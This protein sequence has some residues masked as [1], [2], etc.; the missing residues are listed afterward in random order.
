M[1]KESGTAAIRLIKTEMLP[2]I[3][4]CFETVRD[5]SGDQI[6]FSDGLVESESAF[7]FLLL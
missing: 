4:Y 7:R 3:F 2:E 6:S 5:V 1:S